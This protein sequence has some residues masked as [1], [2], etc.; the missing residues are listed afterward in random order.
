MTI[1]ETE[2]KPELEQE[3][4]EKTST[5][6]S[7]KEECKPCKLNIGAA[8][9]INIC[10]DIAAKDPEFGLDCTLMEHELTE[11][12][13]KVAP[14]IIDKVYKTVMDKGSNE[15]KSIAQ[16]IHDLSYGGE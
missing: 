8:M 4:T 11:K 2:P 9:M 3:S 14:E 7:K 10:K 16:E 6:P 15:D 5:E 12:E 13:E 1:T